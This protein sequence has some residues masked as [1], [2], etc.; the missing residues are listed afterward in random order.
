[1]KTNLQIAE[2]IRDQIGRKA[3]AMLG[4]REFVAW[5]EGPGTLGGLRFK[6]GS[7][8][9]TPSGQAASCVLVTLGSSDTYHVHVFGRSR[10]DGHRPLLCDVENVYVSDL[11]SNLASML[12]A[13]LSL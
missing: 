13:Y 9:R 10:P 4:A 1:M 11:R 7:G 2:T 6:L 5:P 3:F 12:G 8:F